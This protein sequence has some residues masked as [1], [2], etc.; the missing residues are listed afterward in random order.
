MFVPAASRRQMLKYLG[1]GAAGLF[2]AGNAEAAPLPLDTTG[3]EHIGFTVP[4]P[5]ATAKFY[6]RIFDPQLFQEKDPPARFYV[7]FGTAY[8]AFGGTADAMPK[9]DH[10]CALVK[11]YKSQEMRKAVEDAGITMGAGP[12]GMPTDADG[13]RLQ[14]LGVPGGLAKTIIPAYRVNQDDAAVQAIG[15]DH[16]ML[17]VSD[18][19]RSAAHYAKFFGT[20]TS[21]TKNP[22]R[23]WFSAAKTRLGLEQ[24][25][26]GEMPS[27]HH[28]CIRVARGG[29]SKAVADKLAALGVGI[30]PAN[31]EKLLRF[32]DPHGLLMELKEES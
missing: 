9:I 5:E 1:W 16:V 20:E 32:R 2:V 3:L 27:V 23:V 10:F 19:E 28:I 31:D 8:A 22:A 15:M 30:E 4:D 13:L 17:H 7:R 18:L 6:G 11:D 24:A 21:R 14:L 26:A 12:V 25:A 29:A